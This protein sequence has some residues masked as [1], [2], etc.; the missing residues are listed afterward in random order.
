MDCQKCGSKRVLNVSAHCSDS[1]YMAIND[2]EY[3]GYVPTDVVFGKSGYGDNVNF[4]LCLDCGQMQGEWSNPLMT[5]EAN[6]E[7]R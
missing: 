6:Q 1:F 2:N 3:N 7:E 4:N 5:I